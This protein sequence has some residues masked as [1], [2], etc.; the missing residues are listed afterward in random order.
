MLRRRYRSRKRRDRSTDVNPGGR[1][2]QTGEKL[3]RSQDLEPEKEAG[4]GIKN[5]K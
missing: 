3:V 5:G 2:G 4:A 1:W